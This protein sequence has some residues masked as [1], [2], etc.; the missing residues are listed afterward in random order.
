MATN[1]SDSEISCDEFHGFDSN[2]VEKAVD[3]GNYVPDSCDESSVAF[4]NVDIDNDLD[5]NSSLGESEHM[6]DQSDILTDDEYSSESSSEE[7]LVSENVEDVSELGLEMV[8]D[9]HSSGEED[10]DADENEILIGIDD[11]VDDNMPDHFRTYD[12]VDTDNLH[13]NELEA[14]AQVDFLEKS[15]PWRKAPFK[16][17][18]VEEFREEIGPK[19][20]DNWDYCNATPLDYFS[21][22]FNGDVIQKICDNTNHYARYFAEMKRITD[23]GYIDKHW[24]EVTGDELRAFFGI[25]VIFGYSKKSRYKLNWSNDPFLQNPGIK[26]TMVLKRCVSS[27]FLCY[28][29]YFVILC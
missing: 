17:T 18:F 7:T 4:S 1:I 19:L 26:T 11:N 24:Y 8:D 5:D 27:T 9:L 21:L 23:P 20:P 22:F 28:S 13:L 29:L 2:D 10:N 6:S 12:G 3:N 14:K 16:E 15:I 25:N